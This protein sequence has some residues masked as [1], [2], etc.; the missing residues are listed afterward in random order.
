MAKEILNINKLQRAAKK[1]AAAESSHY[2]PKLY[3]ITDG[4][5]I[6][7]YL[8]RNFFAYLRKSYDFE[9]GNAASG[10]DFPSLEVDLKVTSQ[11]QPQSSCPYQSARQKIYGLGYHLLIFVYNKLDDHKKRTAKLDIVHTIF[12]DAAQTADFQMTKGLLQILENEANIDDV[13]AFMQDK[14]LPADE[15]KLTS[16]AKD[17]LA[18]PPKQGYLTISNALQWRIQYRRV[19]Q[20]AGHISGIYK[21]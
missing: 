3:G 8:A 21:M 17:I 15:I 6:G 16:I 14:N 7:T 18:N 4:K 1:F 20:E 19:I 12:V 9:Q 13:I 5:A 11:K 2:Q 10:L